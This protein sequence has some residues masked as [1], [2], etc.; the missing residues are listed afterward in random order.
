MSSMCPNGSRGSGRTRGGACLPALLACLGRRGGR[1]EVAEE[2][3]TGKCLVVMDSQC[4]TQ[5]VVTGGP[6]SK[7]VGG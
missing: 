6:V 7:V 5:V 4:C 3:R 2:V 1:G